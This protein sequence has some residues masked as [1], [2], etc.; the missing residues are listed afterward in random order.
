M[1]N[2]LVEPRP[3]RRVNPFSNTARIVC[4]CCTISLHS[5]CCCWCC[6][7]CCATGNQK[8]TQWDHSLP[9]GDYKERGPRIADV[10]TVRASCSNSYVFG[11]ADD[12]TCVLR[13]YIISGRRVGRGLGDSQ[14]LFM[15]QLTQL[16]YERRPHDAPSGNS[17]FQR[18]YSC[19]FA[20]V[21]LSNP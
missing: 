2:G 16:S 11:A 4:N 18:P 14:L 1:Q 15:A 19:I 10:P 7:W 13:I 12:A 3:A 20:F 17:R 6:F 5:F 9:D 21:R 8:K